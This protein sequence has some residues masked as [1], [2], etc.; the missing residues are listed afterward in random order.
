MIEKPL[1][2]FTIDDMD[3]FVA[4]NHDL[5]STWKELSKFKTDKLS[6]Y[7]NN[8]V[9]SS[10]MD[11][12]SK[13]RHNSDIGVLYA[14]GAYAKGG[15]NRRKWVYDDSNMLHPVQEWVDEH[16][17]LYNLLILCCYIP[18]NGNIHSAK[19]LILMPDEA[20]NKSYIPISV[21]SKLYVPRKGLIE[22]TNVEENS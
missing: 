5:P 4:R 22:I 21:K 13:K 10:W 20:Y 15:F 6:M 11:N 1:N 18:E 12:Y 2:K 14:H 17:G 8:S 7:M 3:I 16:D 9:F 19:S